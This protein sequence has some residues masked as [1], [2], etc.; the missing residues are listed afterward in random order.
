MADRNRVGGKC[1]CVNSGQHRLKFAMPSVTTPCSGTPGLSYRAARMPVATA[2]SVSMPTPQQGKVSRTTHQVIPCRR[3][4][5][6]PRVERDDPTRPGEV[7]V[8]RLDRVQRARRPRRRASGRRRSFRRCNVPHV[9]LA[10][11]AACKREYRSVS[12]GLS[13]KAKQ[14]DGPATTKRPSG[15]QATS[16][17][18]IPTL[19]SCALAYWGPTGDRSRPMMP[20]GAAKC[21][22]GQRPQSRPAIT[23]CMGKRPGPVTV[24]FSRERNCTHSPASRRASLRM[25]RRCSARRRSCRR[26]ATCRRWRT[27]GLCRWAR[28]MGRSVRRGWGRRA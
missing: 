18:L 8:G 27:T 15:V 6:R 2:S 23:T 17:L 28:G 26:E 16:S 12:D 10:V 1:D 7:A 3:H 9:D 22:G 14:R 20:L 21:A 25:R 19:G 11:D 4:H 5:R 13:A 24:P